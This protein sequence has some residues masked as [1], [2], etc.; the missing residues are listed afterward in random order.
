MRFSIPFFPGAWEG[1]SGELMMTETRAF[2]G[3]CRIAK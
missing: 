2:V 3:E 1:P